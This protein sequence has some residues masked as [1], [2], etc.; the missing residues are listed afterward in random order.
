VFCR[1][2]IASFVFIIQSIYALLK[3]NVS[4]VWELAQQ[5]I[6]NILK[7]AFIN[8]FVFLFIDYENDVIILAMNA[9]LEDWKK[10]LMILRNEKKHSHTLWKRYLIK[11]EKKI[12]CHKKKVSW[13]FQ[14]VEKDSFLFLWREVYSED[15]CSRA[16]RSIESIWYRSFW[17]V[18]YSLIRL[19]STFWFW[20][21]S[22]FWYQA[23][24]CRRSV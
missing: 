13:C 3:K 7:I 24:C 18:C 21:S 19:N 5:E 16:R 1:I 8:S 15:K 12:R 11:H 14:N 2:F 22:R 20:D 10:I 4:F 6:T 9:S 17:C 23:Y